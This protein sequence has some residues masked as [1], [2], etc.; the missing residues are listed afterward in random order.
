MAFSSTYFFVFV[1]FSVSCQCV[2]TTREETQLN[3]WQ[4]Q[5]PCRRCTHRDGCESCIDGHFLHKIWG[6]GVCLGNC[7][8][9]YFAYYGLCTECALYQPQCASCKNAYECRRCK[10]PYKLH[11]VRCVDKCPSSTEEVLYSGF[12]SICQSNQDNNY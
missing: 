8:I 3:Q 12:G 9:G 5:W 10:Y 11:D 6:Y 1:V 4:C 2:L 7:P